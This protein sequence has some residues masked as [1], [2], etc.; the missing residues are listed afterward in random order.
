LNAG[1]AG[2][3]AELAPIVA[4]RIRVCR[5]GIGGQF[6]A[7]GIFSDY[8][9][10]PV[11]ADANVDMAVEAQSGLGCRPYRPALPMNFFVTFASNTQEVSIDAAQ[12]GG[13]TNGVRTVNPSANLRFW[14]DIEMASPAAAL[15]FRMPRS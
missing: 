8:A 3:S 14:Y 2:L 1:V 15:P 9:T 7:A 12:C 11:E 4:R 13:M 6:E 5:Y 10:A